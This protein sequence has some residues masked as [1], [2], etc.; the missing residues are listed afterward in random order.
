MRENKERRRPVKEEYGLIF[1][2]SPTVTPAHLPSQ[3]ARSFSSISTLSCDMNL[4]SDHVELHSS[5]L[6][7]VS[8]LLAS[9]SEAHWPASPNSYMSHCL[10]FMPLEGVMCFNHIQISTL[11]RLSDPSSSCRMAVGTPSG[12][13]YHEYS[14]DCM[15]LGVSPLS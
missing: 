12:L 2:G 1:D 3:M 5:L 11:D 4:Y 7:G 15:S 13:C 14:I 6:L 10:I 8:S 9:A